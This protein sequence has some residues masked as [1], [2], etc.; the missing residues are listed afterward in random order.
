MT[1]VSPARSP[2]DTS[3]LPY[4]LCQVWNRP[5][6][7]TRKRGATPEDDLALEEDLLADKKVRY[8]RMP[9]SNALRCEI[10][11]NF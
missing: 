4:L 11:L 3:R 9:A 8:L 7:G 2:S 5:L 1:H 6:A 10:N